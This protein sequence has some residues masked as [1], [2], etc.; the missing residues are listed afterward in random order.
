[1]SISLFGQHVLVTGSTDGL[2]KHLVFSLAKEGA[3]PIIHGRSQE[4]VKQTVDEIQ[5]QYPEIDVQWVVCDLN[6]PEEISKQ[7][8][9]IVS[10]D[11]LINNA[12]VWLEGNTI[13]ANPEKIIKSL[14]DSILVFPSPKKF[15]P[16]DATATIRKLVIE[17][18]KGILTF[19][20]PLESN[21]TTAFQYNIGSKNSR[22]SPERLAPPP[23]PPGALA[24]EPKCLFPTT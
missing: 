7:F 2:G 15:T 22:V 9:H 5:S 16:A 24:L 1:M 8:S 17:S 12:G 21:L 18:F 6:K 11:I 4:K 23:S 13:N 19:A 3:V 14:L 10:L 20:C